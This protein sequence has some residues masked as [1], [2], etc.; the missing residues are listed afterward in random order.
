[1]RH[2]SGSSYTVLGAY[3]EVTPPERLSFTWKW[4]HEE[5]GCETLVTIEFMER[6]DATE[7]VLSHR[8]FESDSDRDE[9]QKGWTGCMN[10]L[11][12]IM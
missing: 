9:H 4:Q 8:L 3:R 6:G 12:A 10:R 11:T 2:P 7:I 5:N 1:M